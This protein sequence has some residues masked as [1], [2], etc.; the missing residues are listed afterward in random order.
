[1][2]KSFIQ[3]YR[4]MSNV[5]KATLWFT[6][7]TILQ[8]GISFI[9]V[10]IFTRIMTPDQYGLFSVYL[11]WMSVL[12]ILG[13]MD[14]HTCVYING[15]AKMEDEKEKDDL[16]VSLLDLS[17]LI[18]AGWLM[19]YWIAKDIANQYM[20]M[21]TPMVLLMFL[22]VFFIPAVNLWSTK[23]R[24]TYQYKKLIAWTLGQV[25]LNAGF[26]ILFVLLAQ[27]E[28]QAIARVSSIALVQVVFGAFLIIWF[29]LRAK[30]IFTTKYW[31]HAMRLHI[32]LLPHKL[33]LT[34]LGSVDRIMISNIVGASY[35]AIYSVAYSASMVINLIKL[36]ISD[37]LTPWIYE[38]IKNKNYEAIRKNTIYVMLLI[39]AMVF[40]FV[41]FAP[42]IMWIVGSKEYREAIYVIPPVAAS[43]FF[44]FLYNLFSSVE[45]YYEETKKTMYASLVAAVLNVVLNLIFINMFGYLAAGYTT[46]ACYIMLSVTHYLVM[47]GIVKN[48]IGDVQLFDLKFILI[49]S[50]V[51]ILSTMVFSISYTHIAVRHGLIIAILVVMA[52]MRKKIIELLKTIKKK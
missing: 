26:G 42:E 25:L 28:F 4:Q 43:V 35:T 31:K 18:T 20:E 50:F 19:I 51:V 29:V 12:T 38:S 40:L 5:A 24:Y 45:F 14:F 22:E 10:P 2:I 21:T 23:Q 11:S 33:S 32:P 48:N 17:F 6:F 15:L 39:L 47:N 46:L 8:K 16:A 49:M 41:L 36:S 1:M 37:A 3:K 44:T 27:E 7:A 52:V 9:T 13:G 34:V 30:K